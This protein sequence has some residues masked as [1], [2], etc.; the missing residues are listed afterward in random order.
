MIFIICIVIG[1]LGIVGT[2]WLAQKPQSIALPTKK[3]WVIIHP[4]V[5]ESHISQ[6]FVETFRE[7][8]KELLIWMLVQYRKIAR[9]ITVKQ[10]VKKRIRNFLA[11]P[12]PEVP[13]EPSEFWNNVKE[14]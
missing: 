1:I 5:W 8:F 10:V 3:S 11:E 13:T 14:D 7:A 6:Y 12:K 2:L 9:R 4:D